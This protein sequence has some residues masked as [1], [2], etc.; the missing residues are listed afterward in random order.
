MPDLPVPVLRNANL[1]VAYAEFPRIDSSTQYL[2]T[3][4]KPPLVDCGSAHA[5]PQVARTF[6]L[7]GMTSK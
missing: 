7:I 4:L 6:E 2:L 5:I 3:V 1:S